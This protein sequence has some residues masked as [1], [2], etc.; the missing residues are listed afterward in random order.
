MRKNKWTEREYNI[1][2]RMRFEGKP[3]SEIAEYLGRTPEACQSYAR[4]RESAYRKKEKQDPTLCWK[5]GLASGVEENGVSCPWADHLEPV[6]GWDA[7][8]VKRKDYAGS[9]PRE[10]YTWFVKQCP[11]FVDHEIKYE[12]DEDAAVNL[13][14]AIIRGM[15]DEFQSLEKAIYDVDSKHRREAAEMFLRYDAYF[16]DTQTGDIARAGLE[17]Y[18]WAREV[19]KAII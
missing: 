14:G 4:I 17:D 1:L 3:W 11:M 9:D 19:A 15:V 2:R 12:A 7:E 16:G 8:H 18:T 13:F 5:C 6:D 10:S